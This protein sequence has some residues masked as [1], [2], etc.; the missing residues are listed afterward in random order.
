MAICYWLGVTGTAMAKKQA[1][2]KK[3]EEKSKAA[4]DDK[5]SKVMHLSTVLDDTAGLMNGD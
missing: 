4:S 1:A 2:N 3:A 5:G